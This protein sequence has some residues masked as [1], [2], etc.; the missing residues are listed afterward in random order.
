MKTTTR[1]ATDIILYIITFLLLQFFTLKLACLLPLSE[2]NVM[3]TSQFLTAILTIF[4]F[5]SQK[6]YTF[7]TRY[8]QTRPIATLFWVSIM[9]LALIFPSSF[10]LEI[11]EVEMPEEIEGV[12]N[13]IMSKPLG[14]IVIGILAPVVEE[15]VFRGATLRALFKVFPEGRHWWAIAISALIFALIHGNFAQGLHAFLIGLLLGWMFYRTRSIIP[16]VI[17]HLVNNSAVCLMTIFTP[18][19]EASTDFFSPIT[20]AWFAILSV[21]ALI[22]IRKYINYPPYNEYDTKQ[23]EMQ[24]G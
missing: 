24:K 14:F 9:S 21:Y 5:V 22:K 20:I 18:E 4:I 19:K 13:M 17:Y 8:L 6:W 3:I 11:L 12:F 7:N 16:G 2:A 15:L 10:M 1:I 23:I